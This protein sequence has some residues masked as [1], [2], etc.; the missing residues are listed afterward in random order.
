[1]SKLEPQSRRICTL[2]NRSEILVPQFSQCH[3][4]PWLFLF[5]V[6]EAICTYLNM[7]FK[8]QDR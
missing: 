8:K 2:A 1:M 3:A 4:Y 5:L 7:A 6:V